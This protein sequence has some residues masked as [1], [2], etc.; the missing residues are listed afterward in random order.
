MKH[1]RTVA[2]LLAGLAV[3]GCR[4]T[5]PHA[6]AAAASGTLRIDALPQAE[7][8]IDGEVAG[9]TPFARDLPAG[10]HEIVLRAT[11][12]ND[13]EES[14]VLIGGGIADID[15]V[16]VA[17]DPGDPE[18]IAKLAE[19]FDIGEISAFEPPVR[20]RG[21]PDTEFAVPLYPRG[22]VRLADL[23]EFR[24]DVGEDFDEEGKL[25]F[26]RRSNVMFETKFDP[27]G[28]SIVA[29]VPEDVVSALKSGAI[30]TWG[31]YPAEG[32]PTTAKFR[33]VREDTRL[34][35]RLKSMEERM[36]G[37]PEIT[38]AQ[39]RAQLYLNKKLYTAAYLEARKALALSEGDEVPPTQALA[40]MQ[41][42]AQRMNLRRTPLWQEIEEEIEQVPARVRRRHTKVR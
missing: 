9:T 31:F 37:H 36:A 22:N 35:K 20:H 23:S 39:M 18:A 2:C 7:V 6:D 25:V 8:V 33:V 34:A 5:E 10:D 17:A 14:V 30:V 21:A 12:F 4:Q 40:V 24:I 3:V 32:K 19:G 28:R 27:E 41:S 26:R 1:L 11:G 13:H 29:P 16:L 15:R 38:L 42:A